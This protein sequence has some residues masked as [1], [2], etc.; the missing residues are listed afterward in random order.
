MAKG[1]EKENGKSIVLYKTATCPW[2]HKTEE[3]LQKH[4]IKFKAIDVGKDEKA[5]N[6]MVQISGQRGVPVIEIDKTVIVGYDESALKK[7]LRL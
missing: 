7:V 6:R 4:K 3:F 2:C 1:K 5:L